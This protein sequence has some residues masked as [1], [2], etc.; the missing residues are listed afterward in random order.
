MS[1]NPYQMYIYVGPNRPAMPPGV[2]LVDVTPAQPGTAAALHAV[3]AA[4]LTAS[5]MRTRT[6]FV[7]DPGLDP[8]QAVVSYAAVCGFAGRFIDFTLLDTVTDVRRLSLP[9]L[10]AAD[11]GKADPRAEVVQFGAPHPDPR[12]LNVDDADE[13][14]PETL[15]AVRSARRAVVHIAGLDG[16]RALELFVVAAALRARQSGDRYPVLLGGDEQLD[17]DLDDP[18][19]ELG[20]NLDSLRRAAADLRRSRRTDDRA[21]IVDRAEPTARARQLIE[22]AAAPVDA[23]L[24]RLGSHQDPETGFWRCPRPERHRN[25]D[26]NPSSRLFENSLRCFRCDPEPMDPLRLV[27]D[28]RQLSPDEAAGWILTG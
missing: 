21:T 20:V 23:V 24:A 16:S 4:G 15:S 22:A 18:E 2:T 27:M 8:S 1:D 14:T 13:L 7:A 28:T 3:E 10:E 5:D 25:G 19:S 9:L 12:A 26:A 11:A 6:L 17:L